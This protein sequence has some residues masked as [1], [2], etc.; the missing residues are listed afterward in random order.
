MHPGDRGRNPLH[1]RFC[2][3]FELGL[4]VRAS[5][6]GLPVWVLR[7]SAVPECAVTLMAPDGIFRVFCIHML[8][9]V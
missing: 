3:C 5:G 8:A 9:S 4:P 2:L 1:G 7:E 6:L